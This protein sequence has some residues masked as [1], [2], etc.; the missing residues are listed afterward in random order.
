MDAVGELSMSQRSPFAAVVVTSSFARHAW[1]GENVVRGMGTS[2]N[3]CGDWLG[4][5]MAQSLI[6]TV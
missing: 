5:A 2:V 3:V 6:P 4:W 1:S